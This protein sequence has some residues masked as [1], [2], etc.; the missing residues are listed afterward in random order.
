M[1]QNRDAV[2]P[3]SDFVDINMWRHINIAC[4]AKEHGHAYSGRSGASG[5]RNRLAN[6]FDTL[7]TD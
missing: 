1:C 4:A 6:I 3:S 7:P 2:A 5:A